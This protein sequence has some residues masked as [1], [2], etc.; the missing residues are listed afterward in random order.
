METMTGVESA[1]LVEAD[2]GAEPGKEARRR[3][4]EEMRT[5]WGRTGFSVD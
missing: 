1:G 4:R 3:R 2:L 5:W